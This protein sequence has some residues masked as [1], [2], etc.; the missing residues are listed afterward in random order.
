[1]FAACLLLII[2]ITGGTLLTF[3]FDRG[4]PRPAR[5]CMGASIGLAL[6]ATAGFLLALWLGLG[7][8]DIVLSAI[9]LLLPLLL[10]LNS[11]RRALILNA[12]RSPA[13]ASGGSGGQSIGY[14]VF[15]LALALLLAMVFNRAAFARPNGIFTGVTNNLGDL[16]LHF[17]VIN[18]FTQGNNLP[19]EDPTYA[20]VRFAYPFLADFLSAMLMRAGAGVISAMWLQNMVLALAFV[21]SLNYWTLLLTRN[22]LAGLIAPLLVLFSGGMGWWLLFSDVSNGDGLFST[23]GNLQHDYTIVPNSILRWGNSLTTL[24]S[25]TFFFHLLVR[26][27]L[28]AKGANLIGRLDDSEEHAV[29]AEQLASWCGRYPDVPVRQIVLRGRPAEALLGYAKDRPAVH[30]PRLLVVGSLGRGGLAGLLLGSTS[31]RLITHTRVPVVVVP[32]GSGQ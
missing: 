15:Y 27:V 14:M 8:A 12:L 10:L 29:L 3:L 25:N 16:P 4:A 32:P 19:P 9:I 2:A 17:Q 6:L 20:G 11:D 22:R 26:Y 18:S 24:C 23:L 7:T 21:G 13:S 30:H 28:L 5:L 1:M 31:Q